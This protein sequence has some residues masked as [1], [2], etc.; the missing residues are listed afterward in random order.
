MVSADGRVCHVNRKCAM[1]FCNGDDFTMRLVK[2][3]CEMQAVGGDERFLGL[4][5]CDE[6]S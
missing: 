2:V 5:S 6:S 3:E 1:F 4:A